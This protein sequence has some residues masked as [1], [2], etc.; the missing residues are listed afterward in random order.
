[1]APSIA[2]RLI[3]DSAGSTYV[4][5]ELISQKVMPLPLPKKGL[6]YHVYCSDLNPGAEALVMPKFDELFSQG[7]YK[8]A[9]AP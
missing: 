7:K 9:A 5:C 4:D 8:E 1:M 6:E 3:S 2:E